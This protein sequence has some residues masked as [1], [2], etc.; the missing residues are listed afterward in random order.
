M[1]QELRDG[2]NLAADDINALVGSSIAE[3]APVGDAWE[4]A[5][6][7][8]LHSADRSHPNQ[9]GRMLTALVL[10]ATIYD[11]DTHDLFLSGALNAT[12]ASMSLGAADGDFLTRVSDAT[13]IPEPAVAALIGVGCLVLIQRRD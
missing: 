12:L 1:Q 8:N 7:N 9:R 5:N 3:V 2:Y 11:D 13:V 10:Y 4:Y 6:Y